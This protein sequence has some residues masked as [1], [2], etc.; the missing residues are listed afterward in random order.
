MLPRLRT[1][2]RASLPAAPD[3]GLRGDPGLFGPGSAAWRVGRERALLLAGPAALLLQV[4][5]PLVGAG[6][7]EHSDFTTDPQ[8]RLR[9]TLEAVLAVTFGDREQAR[10][11]ARRVGRRHAPVRGG[12]ADDAGP[13][14]A[15]TRYTARDA[16]LA[17][18]VWATL[19]WSALRATDA[20]V[21]PVP[22]PDRDAYVRD[23]LQFGRL[24][25]VPTDAPADAAALEAYV[26]EQLDQALDVGP[27]AR[28]LADRILRP[29]PPLLPRPLR[30]APA[31][32][33]AA[34]LPQTLREAYRLPWRRR[35]RTAWAVLRRVLR[36][37]VRVLPRTVREWPHAR[38]A[39][40]RV[41][42]GAGPDRADGPRGSR[43]SASGTSGRRTGA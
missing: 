12:L 15:G 14:P 33:A 3:P 40:H 36:V 1:G 39:D 41:G 31:L 38:V 35:E 42:P 26:Q 37:A 25:G 9:G 4:A 28:A 27:T 34:F 10:D 8:R 13:F 30:P 21:R 11:A 20:L 19:V 16:A 7:A 5:H 24:F 32:L 2:L 22:A 23:M 29:E 18:W 6:V 17:Q 43:L